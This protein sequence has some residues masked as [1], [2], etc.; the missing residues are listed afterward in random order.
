VIGTKRAKHEQTLDALIIQT[1]DLIIRMTHRALDTKIRILDAAEKLFGDKGFDT[2]SLRDITTEADV[3]LASVNYH[4]QS[5]DSLIDAVI[6]RR[7]EPINKKRLDM[8]AQA[9]P[10]PALK[11]ILTAF[12]SPLIADRDV[13]LVAPLIGRILA[14]PDVCR[15]QLFKK[16]MVPVAQQFI[17]ALQKAL[18]DLNETEIMWRL[19]FTA[20]AMA[21]I[22]ARS[23]FIQE[24]TAG[25]CDPTDRPA[26]LARLVMFATAGFRAKEAH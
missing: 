16:H 1:Y 4:F 3:N 23:V 17:A 19:S 12:L 9:G 15:I 10:N 14:T 22:M 21:H 20:G 18:P 11:Q 7:A 8:L 13:S 25:K 2:T 6:A 24:F 26:V 5:K